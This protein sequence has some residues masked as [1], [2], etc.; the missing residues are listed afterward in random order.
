MR[1]PKLGREAQRIGKDAETRV[2]DELSHAD[3]RTETS[4]EL[5][6]RKKTDV[7]A[8]C[9]SEERFSLQ[10]SVKDKSSREQKRLARR[11]I[12]SVSLTDLDKNKLTVPGFLCKQCPLG[13]QCHTKAS[14]AL[15]ARALASI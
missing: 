7:I 14:T 13:E 6:H 10:V 2:V 3:W 5:D 1:N 11:G 8:T 4:P 9:P 15:G 12:V